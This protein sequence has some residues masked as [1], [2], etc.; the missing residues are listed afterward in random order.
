MQRILLLLLFFFA[1]AVMI[2][3]FFWY[4]EIRITNDDQL[5]TKPVTTVTVPSATPI[6]IKEVPASFTLPQS[7]FVSQSFN[8]CGPASL[9]MVMSLLGKDIDQETLADRMRPFH[10]PAGGVDD[11]SIFAQEFVTYAKE[12]GFESL[13]RPNGNI[14]LLKKF[15]ANGI[16]V[17]VR[18]WLHPNEDIGHFRIVRGYNDSDR[19]LLQDDSYEGPNLTFSYASFLSMWQPF[20]FGYILVYPKEKQDEVEAILN[21][22]KDANIAYRNSIKRGEEELKRNSNDPYVLFN[23]A[24]A[25]YH[26]GEYQKAVEYYERAEPQ[27]PPRMLWYQLEPILAYQK[28]GAD[29]SVFQLTSAILNN[30]NLAYSELYQMRG[31]VYL[32]QGNREAAK[33]EFEKAVYYNSNFRSAQKS[34]LELATESQ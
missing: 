6:P 3:A 16:P 21:E 31:E 11:K 7:R 32:K 5:V 30:G 29:E 34:L 12:Y 2:G 28:I 15:V 26:V 27:L 17:I 1:F 24:T 33:A 14:D 25:S 18:T 19:T 13:E 22:E 4:T 8:N 23:L 9:S 10:N 20:N